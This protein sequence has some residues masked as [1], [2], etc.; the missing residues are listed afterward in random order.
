MAG[1][2]S[3][4]FNRKQAGGV[5][6]I[7]PMNYTTG[8]IFFVDSSTGTDGA[9]Q[10]QNPD[11]PCATIDYAVGLCTASK[12]DVIYAMPGHAETLTAAA[13]IALD[14][15]GVSVIGLGNG[16][17]CPT[18]TFGTSTDA[19]VNVSAANCLIKNIRFVSNINSL[20]NFLDL[21]AGN[22]TC[23]DCVFV[24]SSAKEAVTFVDI[25]TTYDDFVFLRCEFYQPSDPEGTDAAAGTGAI[26][27]VDTEG[28]RIEDCIF[29]GYFET[30][31]VHNR[32]TK[33]QRLL[34]KNCEL[35]NHLTFP[36]ELV[37]DSTGQLLNC[38]GESVAATDD[39]EALVY[40]TMGTRFWMNN[41][42]VGNDSGAG[43]QGGVPGA[44][45]T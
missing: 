15:I 12:G 31:I 44:V 11:S 40:G 43:G 29:H 38:G 10:G 35:T 20:K 4:V 25:A 39:S 32:T 33:V 6:I 45:A 41:C 42:M 3:P 34:I 2:S 28:I 9:G 16:T 30:A 23:E 21:D 14:V 7:Q 19:D 18:L 22:F 27:C 8:S 13:G 26:F 24:T 1:A 36:V 17:L 37:A 5:F